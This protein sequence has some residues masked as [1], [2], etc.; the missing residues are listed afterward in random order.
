MDA[1]LLFRQALK[2]INV[3]TLSCYLKFDE[4]TPPIFGVFEVTFSEISWVYFISVGARQAGRYSR[5]KRKFLPAC[6]APTEMKY[7]LINF[8]HNGKETHG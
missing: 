8:D 6:L 3:Y 7:T 2:K 4:I 5:I 1:P